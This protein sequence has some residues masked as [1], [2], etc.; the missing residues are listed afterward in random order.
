MLQKFDGQMVLVSAALL[1]TGCMSMHSMVTGHPASLP[2]PGRG[3]VA[4]SPGLIYE[5]TSYDPGS[6]GSASV[7]TSLGFPVFEGNVSYGLGE[8][9]GL[10]LHLSPGGIQPGVQ[11]VLVNGPLSV[12]ILPEVAFAYGLE[13]DSASAPAARSTWEW[14]GVLAGSKVLVSHATGIY[15]SVGYDFQYSASTDRTDAESSP[16]MTESWH[17]HNITAGLG[18]TI[19][20]GALCLRPEIAALYRPSLTTR[21]QDVS[22]TERYSAWVIMPSLTLATTAGR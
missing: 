4:V 13:L 12:A 20:L 5:R 8:S 17:A 14:F 10:N 2:G 3:E 9:V 16:R 11:L 1:S 18:Y 19:R 22:S 7:T 15:G 21:I 6:G